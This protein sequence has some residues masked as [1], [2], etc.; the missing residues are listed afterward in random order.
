VT[1]KFFK[2]QDA[3]RRWLEANH[4]SVSELWVG[5]YNKQSGKGG[6][7]YREALDEA[8]CYG[9]IDGVRRKVDQLSYTNRFTPRRT[10][11]NWSAVNIKR[12]DELMQAGKL[13]PAGAQ[14][15][16]RR[17]KINAQAQS[18]P[19]LFDAVCRKQFR[20]NRGAWEFFVAQPPGCQRLAIRY[21]MSGKQEATRARRLAILINACAQGRRLGDQTARPNKR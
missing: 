21:V 20:A 16:E 3:L 11:S 14:A 2:S 15:F 13:R 17:S 1:V 12:L 9:W 6:L 19:P 7:T 18:N 4:A 5:F 8:L 10:R